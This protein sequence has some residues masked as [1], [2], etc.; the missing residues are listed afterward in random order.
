[1]RAPAARAPGRCVPSPTMP[2]RLPVMRR[3]SIQVGDHPSPSPLRD[4]A[5]T[6]HQPPRCRQN[7]R[8]CHVGGV[9]RQHAG[10][11]GDGN[12]ATERAGD[13]DMIDPIA[14]IGDQPH[15]IARLRDHRR[16]DVV[17]DGRHENVS[18]AHRLDDLGLRHR[19][20]LEVEPGVEQL[21]HA[22]LDQLRQPPGD[23][24]EGSFLG[25]ERRPYRPRGAA[26]AAPISAIRF[27]AFKR[28]T[29][30]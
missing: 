22:G 24:H 27:R 25:H 4:D 30:R 10:G 1:M 23:H 14:E 11:V 7:Q 5:R 13:V 16:I 12:A 8:H 6:L 19:L 29:P 26:A 18:L 3:P 21:A 2:R 9:L 28:F 17:G 15:L 20:V